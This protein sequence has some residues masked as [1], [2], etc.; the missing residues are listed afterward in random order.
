[1]GSVLDMYLLPDKLNAVMK[2]L[3]TQK[4]SSELPACFFDAGDQSFE[5]EIAEAEPADA[6]L[7]IK[8]PGA[9]AARAPVVGAN[10][11]FRRPL[12]LDD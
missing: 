5:R 9:A 10:C 4:G 12:G 1:M 8:G 6:E 3:V 11:K 7:A 2:K